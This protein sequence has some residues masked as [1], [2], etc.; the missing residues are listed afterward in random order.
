MAAN[1]PCAKRVTPEEA[2]EVYQSPDGM[3]T[4]FVLKKYQSPEKEAKNLYAR[5]H[6][7]VKHPGTSTGD[8]GDV[9]VSTV[10]QGTYRV[11]N[12]MHRFF[13]VK[14]TTIQALSEIGLSSY[15]VSDLSI[16]DTRLWKYLKISAAPKDYE[17]VKRLLEE[18]EIAIVCIDRADFFERCL[19]DLQTS[20]G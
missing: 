1:N 17:K 20:G 7:F 14:Q 12:P 8:Y 2:Y 10:K 5:W 18:H 11:E 19:E 3:L 9:Y 16:R 4:Y 6:C 13:C 15:P